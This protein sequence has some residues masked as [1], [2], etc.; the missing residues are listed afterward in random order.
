M[1]ASC[2]QETQ[3][4]CHVGCLVVAGG[5]CMGAGSWGSGWTPPIML[6]QSIR[7]P[8]AAGHFPSFPARS[9]TKPLKALLSVPEIHF[10]S[11]YDIPQAAWNRLFVLSL[12]SC[13]KVLAGWLEWP[14]QADAQAGRSGLSVAP[15][16]QQN[17]IP[18][19][20]PVIGRKLTH[21]LCDKNCNQNP[22]QQPF[23]QQYD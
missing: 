19:P 14:S 20:H 6:P 10:G 16:Y 15:D 21:N 4:C 5:F 13:F 1:A 7:Q 9:R 17:N 3:A 11:C 23:S 18:G 2:H 22:K 12:L 8:G